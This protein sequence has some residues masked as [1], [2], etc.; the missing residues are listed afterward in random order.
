MKYPCDLIKDILPLYHDSVCSEESKHA[1]EQHF[2]ECQNCKEYYK[3]MCESDMVESV[4]FDEEIEL[5]KAKS[6]QSVKKRLNIRLIVIIVF[7]LIFQMLFLKGISTF[8]REANVEV[9]TD[10]EEYEKYM[11][12]EAAEEEYRKKWGMDES[13]FP[14]AI[15]DSMEVTD[16]QMAYFDPWDAQFLGYLVVDYEKADYDKE[17]TRLTEYEST[18]YQG[19]YGVTGF[20]KKYTLLAMYADETYGF[21]YALTDNEDT[22]I[23]VEIIFC[24]Y[25]LDV[26]CEK[27]IPEK[28]LPTGFDATRNN[29]YRKKMM[30]DYEK[31]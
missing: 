2:D 11:I 21:V 17:V 12:G 9:H 24:N 5:K 27:Y 6:F 18:E 28:Y 4:S 19:Y 26:K 23:Y 29:D 15:T 8:L 20:P 30:E 25:F 31:S 1:V 14:D 13:I 22:I 16:Y 10:I 7:G 3:T